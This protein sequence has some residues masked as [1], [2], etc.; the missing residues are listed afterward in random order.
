MAEWDWLHAAGRIALVLL[1]LLSDFAFFVSLY[2][3]SFVAVVQQLLK[4]ISVLCFCLSSGRSS[5]AI[6]GK[7]QASW[8]LQP[9]Q[10]NT[11]QE[12]VK[13]IRKDQ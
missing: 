13:R 4:L 10:T 12:P 11:R 5:P 3:S 2:F 1:L 7:S 8:F 9:N 6:P